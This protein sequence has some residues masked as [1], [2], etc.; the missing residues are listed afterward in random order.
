MPPKKGKIKQRVRID[1]PLLIATLMLMTVGL[2]MVFSAS[3]SMSEARFGSAYLLVRKQLIWDAVGIVALLVCMRVDYHRWQKW[4]YPLLGS[5]VVTLAAVLVVGRVVKGAK[6]WI[7]FGGFTFQPSELAKLALILWLAD[8]L[9]RHKS[10]LKDFSK[11]FLP[12]LLVVGV[13]CGLIL[14]EPDL[15]TPMMLCMVGFMLLFIAG[16][17]LEHMGAIGLST[18]PLLYYELF[19]VGYRQRRLMAFANPWADAKGTGYQLTQSLLAFG[20]G[21]L[22]GKGLGASTLKLLYLPDPHTDFIFPVIGEELG[23]L[24]A[25]GLILL[26]VFWGFRGWQAAKRAP[27]LFG[28]LLA[29]GITS[30]VLLQATINMSVSCGLLPTKGLPLP[31]VSFGGSSL[32]ITM[33]AVG[34]LL[35]ISGQGYVDRVPDNG[36]SLRVRMRGS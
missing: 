26:F 28:Q 1:R 8:Y 12:A 29:A 19:H 22:F 3:A 18:L 34:I 7:Q 25:G 36:R 20:S 33:T 24:G 13:V 14:K 21:G 32:V 2:V 16:A 17:R 11:G 4:V 35:N 6:R 23:F 30:W 15:G 10:Q 5:A 27:D 31:F 9:D